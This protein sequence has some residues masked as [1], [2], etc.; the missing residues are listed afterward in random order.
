MD[1]KKK[2]NMFCERTYVPI[3]SKPFWMDVVCGKS[4][5]DVWLYE[6]SG[7]VFAAMPYYLKTKGKYKSITKAPLSQ[8]NGIIFRY[9][10]GAKSIKI[11]KFEEEVIEQANEFIV[12][13]ELDVYEQQ[14]QYTFTNWLPFFWKHYTAIP[15]Y[16][17]VI[18]QTEDVE[19][20]FEN[21][22]SKYRKNI[23]KGSRNGIA[24]E[25]LEPEI[26]YQEHNKIFEKQ[27][28]SC[29]FSYPLW[30]ELYNKCMENNCGKILYSDDVNGNIT[31]VLF[32]VWDEVAVYNLLGGGIPGF[33]NLETYD[34]LIWEA[35]KFASRKGLK[36]DFEGSVIK[37][38]SKSYREFGG[39]PKQYFRI[40]KIFN[41]EIIRDEAEQRIKEI[42]NEKRV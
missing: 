29:P 37:R 31:S 7:E 38:I 26:F 5:W 13:L 12:K 16:T 28:L 19:K 21:I 40:R 3:Y 4:N 42:K 1:N 2:Y 11:Q 8:N 17:Y 15:R 30:Q 22:S 10:Q 23:R 36:Y 33:Q 6:C 34:M 41:P 27:G 9:P 35:I 25:G 20:V 39:V 32:I 24:K 18:E 14:Y